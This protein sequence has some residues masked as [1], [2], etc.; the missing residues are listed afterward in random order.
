MGIFIL[1][2]IHKIGVCLRV[3]KKHLHLALL[4]CSDDF[5]R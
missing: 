2:K 1:L 3:Q 4:T 5:K